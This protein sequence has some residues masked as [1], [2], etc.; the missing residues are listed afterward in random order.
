M[1][2]AF[3]LTTLVPS[4]RRIIIPNRIPSEP[5]H[6]DPGLGRNDDSCSL[7][8][9]LQPWHPPLSDGPYASREKSALEVHLRGANKQ[10]L[11]THN[12]ALHRHDLGRQRFPS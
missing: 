12:D 9:R 4:I 2:S 5:S 6:C 10:E 11:R 7:S 8:H 3:T 1:K